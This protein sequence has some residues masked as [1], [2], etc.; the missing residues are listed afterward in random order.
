MNRKKIKIPNI[1]KDLLSNYFINN[2]EYSNNIQ[3]NDI[4][5]SLKK[6]PVIKKNG[7]KKKISVSSFVQL[8]N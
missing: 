3:I 5:K 2:I 7:S 6:G 8:F 1:Y 4:D